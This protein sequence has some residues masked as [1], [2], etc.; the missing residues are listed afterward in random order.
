LVALVGYPKNC[1]PVSPTA[2]MR[3]AT[4]GFSGI[5]DETVLV[6]MQTGRVFDSTASSTNSP[7][8]VAAIAV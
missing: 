2:R 1:L 6:L 5:A 7:R 4:L 3:Q 8:H